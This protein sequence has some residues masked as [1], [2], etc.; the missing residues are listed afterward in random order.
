MG[1][2]PIEATRNSQC[3]DVLDGEPAR[4]GEAVGV[5]NDDALI[6]GHLAKL[7][8]TTQE[9]PEVQ[10][11]DD[12]DRL[13]FRRKE[14]TITRRPIDLARDGLDIDGRRV[15]ACDAAVHEHHIAVQRHLDADQ[16]AVFAAHRLGDERVGELVGMT[17]EY[18]LGRPRTSRHRSASGN[19]RWTT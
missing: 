17:G 8:F 14:R 2:E 15:G 4:A 10:V 1:A 6:V 9:R 12:A 5:P 3:R 16:C 7:G 19:N 13:R 11:G 18:D